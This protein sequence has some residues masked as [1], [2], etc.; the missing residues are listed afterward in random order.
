MNTKHDFDSNELQLSDGRGPLFDR[1]VTILDRARANVVRTVNGEM[2][3]AYWLIG[4]EIVEALQAGDD[5]AEYG[6]RLIQDLSIQLTQTYGR[7]FSITNL[8]HFRNFYLS[9]ADRRPEIQHTL[10]ADLNPAALRDAK[11]GIVCDLSLAIEESTTI[12]GFSA[13]LSWSHYRELMKVDHANARA[14]YEIEAEKE[15]WSVRHLQR[16]IHTH[17]F[18]RLLKSREKDGVMA[19]TIEGQTLRAPLDVIKDPYVLDFLGLPDAS[20]IRES[21]LETAIISNLQA[22]LLELGKG[23]AFVAR[24]KRIQFDDECFFVDL[25]FYHCILKCYVLIDLKIGKLTHQ[26]IGQMDSYIRM[27]DDQRTTEGDNPTIGLILCSEKNEV[28]VKYSVLHESQQ[29]FAAKYLAYLPSEQ[30][31]RSELMRERELVESRRDVNDD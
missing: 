5:R 28:I 23:F 7:G 26:D 30:E 3:I 8:Q 27:F 22:F 6:Q 12:Q 24:Q 4:R 11:S 13:Q 17:L 1:V 9:Y 20:R 21:D 16:Q 18:I 19:L 2:I 25:V 31:L 10:C 14:F 15:G 29:L